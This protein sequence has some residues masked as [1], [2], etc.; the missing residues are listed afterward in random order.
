MTGRL[1]VGIVGLEAGRSW[2]ALAH[3]P[4]LRALSDSFEI[5]G[6]ANTSLGSAAAAAAACGIP[7][8][9]ESVDALAASPNIDVVAVTVKVPHHRQ[10]VSAAVAAGKHV[11]C[12][13]PLGNGLAEAEEL[14]ALVKAKGV[15]GVVGTQA[16]AAPQILHL[17]DLVADGFVGDVLSTTLTGY[18]GGWGA[19]FENERA[20]AYGLDR[21]NGAT[22][23]TVSVGHTLAA[24]RDVLGDID[25]VSALL[26]SRRRQARA[27]DTG[28]TLPMTAPDQVLV[29][30]VLASGAPISIHYRGGAPRGTDGFIWEINGTAGDIRVTAPDGNT[31]MA[32]LSLHGGRGEECALRPLETPIE[33]RAGAPC[34][35]VTGNV[36]RIYARMAAELR[37]GARNAPSFADALELHRLIAAIEHAD[38][39]GRSLAPAAPGFNAQRWRHGARGA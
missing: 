7:Q 8:A 35:A 17:R 26:A 36:A 6:V 13:W 14:A 29:N 27:L 4:A 11:Y 34:D 38:D 28:A 37:G 21:K 2:G 1:R 22:M 32:P 15:L 23:L 39:T 3:V 16:R 10:V 9:F 20:W 31:Q 19:S 12:E 5:V 25:E 18:G 33:Y 24:V 30:G